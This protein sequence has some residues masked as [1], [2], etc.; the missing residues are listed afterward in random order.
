MSSAELSGRSEVVDTVE[1]C[2]E[3]V[4]ILRGKARGKTEIAVDME[5]VNHGRH[6][7]LSLV[8]AC[9]GRDEIVYLFDITTLKKSAFD[10][11]NLRALFEDSRVCKVMFD[12]RADSDSLFHN[13]GCKLENVYDLQVL[14][15]C[16][17][18][19]PT[20]G[21]LKGLAKVLQ[22]FSTGLSATEKQ[23]LEELKATGTGMFTSDREVWERRPLPDALQNYAAADVRYLLSMKR[24]WG[25]AQYD[26]T[27]SRVSAERMTKQTTAECP[28]QGR[29]KARRDFDLELFT[30]LDKDR[31]RSPR[32]S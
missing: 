25:G 30:E 9:A 2:R 12:V 7:Q 6:G 19:S 11:G 8:Q 14:Y 32:R 29:E 21:Y 17:F 13:Y 27:V 18:C 28:P 31:S 15:C 20:D 23:N 10:D 26:A 24:A 22:A 1:R 5:G 3:V 4:A 16:K